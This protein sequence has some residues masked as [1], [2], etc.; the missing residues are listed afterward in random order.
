[1]ASAPLAGQPAPPA[2]EDST[3]SGVQRRATASA[4]RVARDERL[5]MG[6]APLLEV[7]VL[8]ED[9]ID[10]LVEHVLGRLADEVRVRVQRL[11]GLPIETRAMSNELLSAGARLDQ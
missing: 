2:A 8:G 4:R 10:H 7:L 9:G 6:G 3:T 11:V 1:M 5:R